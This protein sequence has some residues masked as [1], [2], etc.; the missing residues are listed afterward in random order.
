M[1]RLPMSEK[2]TD[3][4]VYDRLHAALLALGDEDAV[5]IHGNTAIHAAK[6]AISMFEAALLTKMIKAK[7]PEPPSGAPRCDLL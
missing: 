1:Y 4:E 7:A 3:L 6:Q 2:L 5:T